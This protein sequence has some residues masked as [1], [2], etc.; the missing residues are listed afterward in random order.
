MTKEFNF[1]NYFKFEI[2]FSQCLQ[3]YLILTKQN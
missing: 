1:S 3:G 2:D